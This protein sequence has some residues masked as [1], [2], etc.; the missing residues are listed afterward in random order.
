MGMVLIDYLNAV[1]HD[2][3]GMTDRAAHAYFA[4]QQ[5]VYLRGVGSLSVAAA[6]F[7][8]ALLAAR[9]CWSFSGSGDRACADRSKRPI[10]EGWKNVPAQL[11]YNPH[12]RVQSK[13]NWNA[14]DFEWVQVM[15]WGSSDRSVPM[16]RALCEGS[17]MMPP[18]EGASSSWTSYGCWF[19][20]AYP[21][22]D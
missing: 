20:I 12:H 4:R 18:G 5:L 10:S 1:F 6:N 2:C 9:P 17:V 16:W 11:A 3:F 15:R 13:S 14:S 21:R 22:A 7:S 8:E 19:F